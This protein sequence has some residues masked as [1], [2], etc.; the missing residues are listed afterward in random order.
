M[1]APVTLDRDAAVDL[2][3]VEYELRADGKISEE[4]AAALAPFMD[5]VYAQMGYEEVNGDRA[6]ASR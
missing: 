3:W 5:A 6:L 1:T 2:I 4:A